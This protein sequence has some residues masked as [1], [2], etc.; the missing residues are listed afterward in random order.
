[1]SSIPII[2]KQHIRTFFGE[3][4]FQKGMQHVRDGAIVNPEQQAMALKAYCYG[5]LPEPYRVQ[6][7]FDESGITAVLCSCST[8]TSTDGNRRCE[9]AAALL[10]AWNEQPEAF[11]KMDGIDIILERQSKAQ[12]ITLVKQLLQKQPE[13]EWQLTMPPLPGHKSVPIDTNEYRHQV[14]EA[15]R[16]AGRE[17]DAVY[18]ISSDLYNI[19]GAAARFARQKDYANAAAIYEVVAQ[20][21]LSHYL[22]YHD[23]DGA[24]GRVV[25]DCVEGLGACLESEREDEALREQILEAIFSVY[26]FDVNQGGFGL[27][28]DI[29]PEFLEETTPEEKHLVAQWVRTALAEFQENKQM[30]DWRLKHFGG[31]LLALEADVLSDEEFLHIGRETKSL[32]EVVTRLLELQ[33]VDEAIQEAAQA[34]GWQLLKFADLFVQ[35]GQETAVERMMYE[36]AQQETYSIAAEWLKNHSLA[37]N[38]LAVAL[39]MAQLIFRKRPAFAEYQKMREISI[40]IGNWEAVRQEALMFLETNKNISTLVE[41]ALDEGDIERALQ[42]LQATKPHGL[43]SYQWKYNYALAPEVA[44]K[45]AERAEE[46]YPHASIDLYQQYAEQLITRHGRANYQVACRYIA[47]IR[48]LC[49]KLDETEQWTSYIAWIRKRHS[50]L[51]TLKEEMAAAGL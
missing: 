28:Q 18:G 26:C 11:T 17:W 42:L 1:M 29:P 31:L 32:L 50:R 4:N 36:K 22:S 51:S 8:G 20:G 24:L 48:S 33:R 2:T 13:V 40:E 49:E 5:S 15:F 6:V 9:H 44:L 7:T 34:Q 3:Q 35:Y 19:T 43:E 12:L 10:L 14:D 27:T 45:T 37:K 39:E 38:N 25:Q 41:V 30:S 23:E 47:K 21:T 46:A 16:H